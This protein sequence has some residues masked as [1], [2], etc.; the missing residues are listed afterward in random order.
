M[1]HRLSPN[2]IAALTE[3]AELVKAVVKRHPMETTGPILSVLATLVHDVAIL[4]H[5]LDDDVK[6]AA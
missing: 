1:S 4:T 5:L 6:E 3:A 2:D